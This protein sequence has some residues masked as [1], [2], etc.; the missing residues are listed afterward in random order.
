MEYILNLNSGVLHE[1]PCADGETGQEPVKP[2]SRKHYSSYEN[3]IQDEKYDH[4]HD[5]PNC[6]GE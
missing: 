3:A 6:L 4:D 2:G 1:K 5:H